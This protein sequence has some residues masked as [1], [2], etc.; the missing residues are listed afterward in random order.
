MKVLYNEMAA[1]VKHSYCKSDVC[2]L[3]GF[4]I[5][6]RYRE[7]VNELIKSYNI[8]ASHFDGGRGRRFKYKRILKECPV[9]LT[10][11]QALG[12]N[13]REKMTCSYACSN[14]YFR[15]G[16]NNPNWKESRYT[17]TCFLYHQKKCIACEEN[18]I[19]EVHHRDND[20]HNNAPENLIPLCPTHHKYYHSRYKKIIE[21]I[22]DNYV[23]EREVRI[24]PQ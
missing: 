12:G 2:R 21:P 7:K 11:F 19:V 10:K 16:I 4:P 8:D 17:T 23:K 14:S 22:I 24:L 13:P 9:C 18:K 15:S 3:L 6:G 1:A 5:N 20:K